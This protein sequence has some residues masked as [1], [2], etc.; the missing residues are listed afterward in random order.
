MTPPSQKLIWTALPAGRSA[1]QLF[2]SVFLTPQL[3]PGTSPATLATFPDFQNW[4]GWLTGAGGPIGFEVEFGTGDALEAT[5]VSADSLDPRR[6]D[7]V[8]NP[9]APTV[10]TKVTK[11]AQQSYASNARH[12]FDA[13]GA[14]QFVKSLYQAFGTS[15]PTTPPVLTA[16]ANG[17]LTTAAGSPLAGQIEQLLTLTGKGATTRGENVPITSAIDYYLRPAPS[18]TEF[19]EPELLILDFHQAFS[20][21]GSFPILMRLFGVVFD[22]TVPLPS[23]YSSGDSTVRVI[24]AWTSQFTGGA[25]GSTTNVSPFTACTLLPAVFQA[26]PSPGSSDYGNGMLDLAD[27]T[28]FS[29]NDLDVDGAAQLLGSL[30]SSLNE[31]LAFQAA[32]GE[33]GAGQSMAVSLPALRTSGPSLV[34]SGFSDELGALTTR[35]SALA[36]A[37]AKHL[38][39]PL[40][41]ADPLPTFYAQD[42][43]RGHRFDVYPADDSDPRWYSL[44]QRQG[45]YSFGP[46]AGPGATPADSLLLPAVD[47]VDEGFVTPG[48]TQAVGG[49]PASN[50]LYIHEEICRWAG[51]SLAAPRV[52]SALDPGDAATPNPGNPAIGLADSD[53]NTN[54]QLSASFSVV[55]GTLPKLRFGNSY[56]FR[57]RGVDLAG[58]GPAASSTDGSTATEPVTH[59]RYEPV[60]SPTMAATAP[61]TPGQGTLT[62]AILNDMVNTPNP[63][64]R[65]LLPPRVAQLVAEEHGMFDGFSLGSPPNPALAPDGSPTTYADIVQYDQGTWASLPAASTDA[66]SGGVYFPYPEVTEVTTPWLAD[67]LAGGVSI[68]GLP[69]FEL[70]VDTFGAGP[71]PVLQGNLLLVVAGVT[72]ATDFTPGDANNSPMRVVSLPPAAIYDLRIASALT[73]TE[74]LET[75]G[76]WQWIAENLTPGQLDFYPTA[77][78]GGLLWQLT[79][80]RTLRI[81]HATRLPI[82]T[83]GFVAPEVTQRPANSHTAQIYD[84]SFAHDAASTSSIDVDAYWTDPV[85]DPSD[86]TNNPDRDTITTTGAA[87]KVTVPDPN[88]PDPTKEPGFVVPAPTTFLLGEAP[89]V[90]HDLGD[91]KYHLV[92]YTPTGTSRFAEFFRPARPLTP[93][94]FPSTAPVV[95]SPPPFGLNPGAVELTAPD[96]TVLDPS[97][98]TV[99]PVAGTISLLSSNP[100]LGE[101]LTVDYE[102]TVT[103]TGEGTQVQVLSSA[104][105]AMP[106]VDRVMPAWQLT[107]S[108]AVSSHSLTYERTGGWLR[109]WLERPWWSSGA[110][111]MLGVVTLPRSQWSF[112]PPAAPGDRLATLVGL[113]PIVVADASMQVRTTPDSLGGSSPVPSPI[114]G[115]PAYSNPP[116]LALAENTSVPTEEYTI[117]PYEVNYDYASGRWYAD[118]QIVW[119]TGQTPP[120]GYFVRLGLVRFQPYSTAGVEVSR[121]TLATFAQ[122]VA[123]RAVSVT[124]SGNQ[125]VRVVVIGPAYQGYR[126]ARP[127][128][129][130]GSTVDDIDNQFA[131]QTYSYGGG[132]PTTSTI[133]VE[134]QLQN[135]PGGLSGDFGWQTVTSPVA[136]E[137]TFETSTALWTAVITLPQPIGSATPMRL[138]VNE[139]DYY[140]GDDAPATV[141]TSFRRPFVAHLPID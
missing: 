75:L 32:L 41:P 107:Q 79:P 34:W 67:P 65:W 61:F 98:Y 51:W 102:P 17:Q 36:T 133:T 58:N 31:T 89:G 110:G 59:Y 121:V 70:V 6:W 43:I 54:P 5:V 29:V 9:S 99:D 97:T 96:G 57:A 23:G 81:A 86:P 66:Q 26:T 83:P 87:F 37:L 74:A 69:G 40:N 77:A 15:S 10:T 100:Y 106:V 123:D 141:D 63:L 138:R 118:V 122:P 113:D 126:P 12:S 88:P 103:L 120:P 76:T 84:A 46:D 42:L 129:D 55:P 108:G 3:D 128:G 105:P 92:T 131:V 112:G 132:T 28:R 101:S 124:A 30:N 139:L 109:V 117:T 38:A 104:R 94:P 14:K 44:H 78:I 2:L 33:V 18:S 93:I 19:F 137:P 130:N 52:G 135:N 140:T 82:L 24:P 115:R 1:T 27:T 134:V 47:S 4:P 80:Y 56:R 50:D 16:N 125:A 116:H 20:A 39:H 119:P 11:F 60:S 25:K 22:L 85:D 21:L 91:T 127:E 49:S 71:W 90:T 95:I 114:H 53:G 8:F 64:G 68:T 73:G 13:A 7:L 48:A 72:A 45:S 35:Q 111:E 62:L 136:L